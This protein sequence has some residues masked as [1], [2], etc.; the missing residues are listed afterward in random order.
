MKQPNKIKKSEVTIYTC[1]LIAKLHE[2]L[3]KE[4]GCDFS[5]TIL[6]KGKIVAASNNKDGH[7]EPEMNGIGF[8]N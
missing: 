6:G 3:K 2:A 7:I 1:G 5:Y 8:L 4:F